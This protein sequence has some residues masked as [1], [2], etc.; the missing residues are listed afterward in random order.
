LE[1]SESN[2]KTGGED[3]DAAY[4]LAVLFIVVIGF[5][6]RRA[7]FAWFKCRGLFLVVR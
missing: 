1:F 2:L 7:E 6:T 3:G 4:I 5:S